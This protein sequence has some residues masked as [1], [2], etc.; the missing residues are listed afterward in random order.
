MRR[1]EGPQPLESSGNVLFSMRA[2]AERL[3]GSAVDNASRVAEVDRRLTAE[4][5]LRLARHS[6][7]MGR[8]VCPGRSDERQLCKGT[9]CYLLTLFIVLAFT[10][11]VRSGEKLRTSS[12][13]LFR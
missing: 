5:S 8:F 9:N 3:L 12:P 13:E 10:L 2:W 7:E 1:A 11:T 4:F 6:I